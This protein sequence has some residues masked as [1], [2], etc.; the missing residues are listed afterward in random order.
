MQNPHMIQRYV[1]KHKLNT[2]RMRDIFITM[3]Q[4]ATLER[5]LNVDRTT[6]KMITLYCTK[7]KCTMYIKLLNALNKLFQL[8]N[9]A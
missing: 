7:Y 4:V 6:P 9:I 8:G 2:D 3:V 1:M 5:V